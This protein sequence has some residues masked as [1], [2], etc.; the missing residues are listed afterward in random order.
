MRCTLSRPPNGPEEAN[1]SHGEAEDHDGIRHGRRRF[2]SGVDELHG[3]D[4]EVMN[5][6]H[7]E[8][9]REGR[10]VR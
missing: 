2:R 10:L 4:G 6:E 1:D 8:H 7:V 9:A 5:V 3:H